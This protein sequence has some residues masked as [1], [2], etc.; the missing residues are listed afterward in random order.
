MGGK[1]CLLN[2]TFCLHL[3]L[4]AYWLGAIATMPNSGMILAAF[5]GLLKLTEI[6]ISIATERPILLTWNGNIAIRAG[7]LLISMPTEIRPGAMKYSDKLQTWKNYLTN[8]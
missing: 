3:C 5:I 8:G 7:L 6:L 4:L 1:L 2:F